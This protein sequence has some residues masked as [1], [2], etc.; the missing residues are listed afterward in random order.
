MSNKGYSLSG[1]YQKEKFPKKPVGGSGWLYKYT[2]LRATQRGAIEYPRIKE[3][4]R[5]PNNPKH[6]YWNYCWQKKGKNGKPLYKKGRAVVER[7]G[8]PQKKVNAVKNAIAAKLPHSQIL[9]II[10]KK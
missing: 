2:S 8:C 5:D 3:E 9:E 1:N 4:Q 10:K 6:W 7:V